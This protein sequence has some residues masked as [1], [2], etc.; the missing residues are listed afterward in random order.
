MILLVRP[1]DWGEPSTVP[2]IPAAPGAGDWEAS[3]GG[4][5]A[6]AGGESWDAAGA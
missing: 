6:A 3:A 1:G 2:G 4:E 5:W